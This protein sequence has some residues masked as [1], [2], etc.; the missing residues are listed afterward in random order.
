M[1]SSWKE[2]NINEGLPVS[3]LLTGLP[4]EVDNIYVAIFDA[5]CRTNV[6]GRQWRDMMNTCFK[7]SA[8]VH[9]HLSVKDN[10]VLAT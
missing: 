9:P 6:P 5:A 7:I 10:H 8:G 2:N 3:E 1:V 4:N